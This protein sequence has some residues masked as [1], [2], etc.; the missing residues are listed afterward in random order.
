MFTLTGGNTKQ[1][2]HASSI[3]NAVILSLT[4][5]SD[6][7]AKMAKSHKNAFEDG[8]ITG[9][10]LDRKISWL[11]PRI[12][13]AQVKMKA[14]RCT[15]FDTIKLLNSKSIFVQIAIDG[16]IKKLSDSTITWAI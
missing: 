3:I 14:L 5:E 10:T 4:T 6:S 9:K 15:G 13:S 7:F 8:V 2:A 16:D 11:N 1:K 12:E